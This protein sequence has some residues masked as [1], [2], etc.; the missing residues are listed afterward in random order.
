MGDILQGICECGF[1][2]G[3]IPGGG[4]FS[5][6]E[7]NCS[8]PAVCINCKKFLVKNYLKKYSKCPACRKKVT[9]Y[10]NPSLQIEISQTGSNYNHV[11]SWDDFYLPDTLYWCPKCEKKKMRFIDVGC[12]D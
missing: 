7:T 8:A 10:N 4:G 6:F 11:F 1:D 5:D 12:F 3:N 9:F 2:T